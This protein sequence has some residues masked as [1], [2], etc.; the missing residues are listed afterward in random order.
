MQTAL[1]WPFS[2][3]RVLSLPL[4]IN[5]RRD[6][7]VRLVDPRA[8]QDYV[9]VERAE[10]DKFLQRSARFTRVLP[11]TTNWHLIE[12]DWVPFCESYILLLNMLKKLVVSQNQDESQAGFIT[13]GALAFRHD[14]E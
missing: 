13:L 12:N 5:E 9:A 10:H 14:F 2:A 7:Q 11:K 3:S 8:L 4:R 6:A 1:D